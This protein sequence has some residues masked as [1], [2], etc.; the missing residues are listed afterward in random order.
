MTDMPQ[1]QKDLLTALSTSRLCETVPFE[2]KV[3]M[4][5]RGW[6]FIEAPIGWAVNYEEPWELTDAGIMAIMEPG[7]IDK[8]NAE[9]DRLEEVKP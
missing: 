5:L 3:K 8:I 7:E 4:A 2:V 1:N 6:R 9:L